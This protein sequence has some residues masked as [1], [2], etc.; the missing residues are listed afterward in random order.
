MVA[1]DEAGT[2]EVIIPELADLPQG[3]YDK[4]LAD[5]GLV[6]QAGLPAAYV[7][8]LARAGVETDYEEFA[9]LSGWAFSFGYKYGDIS[10]AFMAVDIT[11]DGKVKGLF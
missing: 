9:A 8:A 11:P 7:H 4:S 1:A 10:P 5:E 6:Y 2:Q 3:L